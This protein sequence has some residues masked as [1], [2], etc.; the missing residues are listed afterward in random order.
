V[1][2]SSCIE[3]LAP[4]E[5][6]S[7]IG[8]AEDLASA[9]SL[10]SLCVNNIGTVD[11]EWRPF[12]YIAPLLRS[13]KTT[14]LEV[15]TLRFFSSR[16]EWESMIEVAENIRAR[17][18]VQLRLAFLESVTDPPFRKL[19]ILLDSIEKEGRLWLGTC[20][21]HGG[22]DMTLGSIISNPR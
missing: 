20:G 8:S 5:T 22:S 7:I 13:V 9:T 15:V 2:V 19:R 3:H 14:S 11:F 21:P 18:G 6:E 12:K 4:V 10:R 17:P 16:I 1:K